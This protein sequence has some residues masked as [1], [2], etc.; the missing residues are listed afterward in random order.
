MRKP[1]KAYGGH[2]RSAIYEFSEGKL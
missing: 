2:G 1:I